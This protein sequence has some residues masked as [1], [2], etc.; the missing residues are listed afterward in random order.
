MD[1]NRD[2]IEQT[3][4]RVGCRVVMGLRMF[5]PGAVARHI[6]GGFVCI[7]TGLVPVSIRLGLKTVWA[8]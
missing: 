4:D 3:E 1:I 8:T 7:S 5:T 2:I 6:M